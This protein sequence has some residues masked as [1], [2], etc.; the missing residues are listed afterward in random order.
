MHRNR[1]SGLTG[2]LLGQLDAFNRITTTFGHDQSNAFCARYAE[3]LRDCLPQDAPIIRLSER[4]FAVLL[5]VDSMSGVIDVAAGLADGSQPQMQVGDDTFLVDL[6]LG[7]AVHPTHADDAASLFRRAELALMEARE[8]ELP[9]GIYQPEST[10]Q[11]AAMWKLESDLE[12]AVQQGELEVFFQPKLDLRKQRIRGVE[13]LVRW[14]GRSG[15]FVPPEEFIP[16][17]ER[18]GSIVPLTWLVFDRVGACAGRWA[19]LPKPFSVAVNIAPSVLGHRELRARLG[20]LKSVLG[21]SG[22]GL[23][24]EITEDS[25]VQSADASP[26]NLQSLRDIGV[27][28]AIDDFGKGYSSLSYLKEI[29][30]T[31]VKIDRRFIA[32]IAS[33]PKDR[34]IVR[35]VIELAHAFGMSVVAE[36]V[37]SDQGLAVVSGL[38]CEMAQ[39]FLIARPMRSELLV[40]WIN[41]YRLAPIGRRFQQ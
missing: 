28:L 2:L 13:A 20:E 18:S 15:N 23:A 25:L 16:I 17:A 40:D 31:E 10:R 3:Q 34:Q 7:V 24:L 37:D 4:R 14:R 26:M 6:T 1:G 21:G 36:G 11:H 39:G 27:D 30:A 5:H 19:T 41:N 22:I 8:H 38:G 9:F 35:S 29:P 33:D 32:T 12:R